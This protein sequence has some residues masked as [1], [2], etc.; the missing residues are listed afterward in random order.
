M[1]IIDLS[2]EIYPDMPV[3]HSLPLVEMTA[4]ANYEQWEGI[5]DRKVVS[6]TVHPLPLKIH[7][8]TGSPM[9]SVA[10]IEE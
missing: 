5:T 4:Y 8:G 1:E 9:R 3:Y 10:V 2:Q 7:G 6:P